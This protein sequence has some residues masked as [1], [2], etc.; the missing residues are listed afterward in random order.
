MTTE[1]PAPV[2]SG[3]RKA[4]AAAGTDPVALLQKVSETHPNFAAAAAS[5]GISESTLHRWRKAMG[6]RG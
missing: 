1:A 5:L 6:L 2:P 4:A 3:L